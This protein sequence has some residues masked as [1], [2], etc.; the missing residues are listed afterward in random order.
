MSRTKSNSDVT[1]ECKVSGHPIEMVYWVHNAR[2]LK[3]SER[4][5]LSEDGLRLHIKNTQ[6]EDQGVY[7][8]FASNSRDQAYGIS[9]YVINGKL[10]V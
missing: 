8:C 7:Q 10:S 2:T 1:F 6:V 4:V 5:K 3:A 9:E